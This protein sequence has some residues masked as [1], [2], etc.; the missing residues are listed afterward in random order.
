[1]EWTI[2]V[3]I[4][5]IAGTFGGIIGL[6]GGIIIVPSLLFVSSLG[7]LS[8]TLEHQNAVGISLMVM[9]F[10][11][12]ASTLYNYKQKRVDIKSGLSFFFA[13]GPA[14]IL[15]AITSNYVPSKHFS[16][17]FGVLMLAVTYLLS[18]QKEIKPKKIKWSVTREYIDGEGNRYEYGYNRKVSFAVTGFAGFLS[19]L[20]GIGGGV[21]LIPMMVI[22][23]RFPVHVA[24]ATSMFIILLSASM[25]SIL[26]ITSGNVIFIYVL[27]IGIGAYIGGRIGAFVSSKMSGKSLIIALRLVIIVVGIQMIYKGLF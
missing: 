26:H 22:L 16:I 19:G 20:L 6:G 8:Y 11:T 23:F 2:L 10:I 5:L 9:I 24:T 1:M 15:G 14:A 18:K 4:G 17:I 7:L 27:I 21:I 25:G 12:T 13:S 3:A